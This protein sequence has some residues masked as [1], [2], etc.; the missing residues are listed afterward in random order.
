[1]SKYEPNS[2]VLF[3]VPSISITFENPPERLPCAAISL[4]DKVIGKSV[5]FGSVKNPVDNCI[6]VLSIYFV[7]YCHSK[8]NRNLSISFCAFLV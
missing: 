8:L 7:L 4:T 6:L 5:P 3:S 2:V 1:M